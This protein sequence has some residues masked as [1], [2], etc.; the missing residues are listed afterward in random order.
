M[1]KKNFYDWTSQT[2]CQEDLLLDHWIQKST[3]QPIRIE[4]DGGLNWVWEIIYVINIMKLTY[5]V[6]E[7]EKVQ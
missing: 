1:A 7:K 3:L 2:S 4:L 5:K 6:A